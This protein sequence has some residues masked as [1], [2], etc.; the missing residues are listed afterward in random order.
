MLP[1]S[2]PTVSTGPTYPSRARLLADPALRRH[3]LAMLATVA[4]A[5]CA[6]EA[7]PP[8]QRT[9]GT[10]AGPTTP[11]P[12]PAP[13]Q[14]S[15]PATPPAAVQPL[16]GDSTAPQVPQPHALRGE[17]APVQAPAPSRVLGQVRSDTP[18]PLPAKLSDKP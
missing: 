13:M 10:P 3:A 7:A 2:P 12:A 11:V 8:A 9:G 1:L 6:G 14:G 16:R 17:A 15:M 5:G 4:L 18:L